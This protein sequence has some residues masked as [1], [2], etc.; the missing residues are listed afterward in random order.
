M[1]K[2]PSYGG[3]M[4]LN[5]ASPVLDGDAPHCSLHLEDK[6]KFYRHILSSIADYADGGE[7]TLNAC[8]VLNPE[9]LP[10][11][12]LSQKVQKILL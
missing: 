4:L 9:I 8:D 5:S 12:V 6:G 1:L 11:L 3:K 2:L 10:D 7:I